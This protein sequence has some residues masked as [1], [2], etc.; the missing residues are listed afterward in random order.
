MVE[1]TE[2]M[3]DEIDIRR[4]IE[5][6]GHGAVDFV[7]GCLS[8]APPPDRR[9]GL[10]ERMRPMARRVVDDQLAIEFFDFQVVRPCPRK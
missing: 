10:V 6:V 5:H 3:P 7:D 8:V 9:R 2:G 1:L 4:L